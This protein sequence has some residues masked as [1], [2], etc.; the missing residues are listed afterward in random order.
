MRIKEQLK[1]LRS[2]EKEIKALLQMIDFE[3]AKAER[4]TTYLSAEQKGGTGTD[5]RE[6]QYVK[7][8]ELSHYVNSVI[9]DLVDKKR[10]LMKYVLSLD[11][12]DERSV[13]V[14][15]YFN[16]MTWE[17]IA[18]KQSLSIRT[19]HRLHGDALQN[20]ERIAEQNNFEK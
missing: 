12:C 9:D 2:I 16:D 5:S 15:R 17:K 1:E 19:I 20:L 6:R 18:E 3:R 10:A 14:N 4:M 11:S 13:I 8:I 7:L